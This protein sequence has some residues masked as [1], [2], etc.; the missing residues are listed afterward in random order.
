[1]YNLCKN[2]FNF[3]CKEIFICCL[4]DKIGATLV[5]AKPAELLNVSVEGPKKYNWEQCK[6]LLKE[7]KEIK[8]VEIRE[9]RTKRQ[10]LFYH[11]KSLDNTL[12]QKSNLKFLTGLNYPQNYSLEEYVDCLV[13]KIRG[14]NFPHEIGVFLGYPLKDVLGF[15]GRPC[16]KLVNIKGWRVYGDETLSCKTYHKFH[17]ARQNIRILLEKKEKPEKIL[18]YCEKEILAENL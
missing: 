6:K 2:R 1:M 15:F 7:H 11:R 8:I 12:K 9:R 16:L 3:N 14:E 10:V 13:T 18:L 17:Q 5:G 4:F